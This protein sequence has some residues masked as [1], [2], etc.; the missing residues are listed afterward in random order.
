MRVTIFSFFMAIIWSSIIIIIQYIFV[1]KRSFVKT[2][3]IYSILFLYMFSALRILLPVELPFTKAFDNAF[4]WN[5]IYEFLCLEQVSI[6][7][8]TFVRVHL[9]LMLWLSG[10]IFLSIWYFIRYI[11]AVRNI[12][13]LNATHYIQAESVLLEVM[14]RVGKQM[15]VEV[16]YIP[17]VASPVGI[18][19]FNK[20]VLLPLRDCSEDELYYILMHE[21]THFLNKDISVKIL[22]QIFCCIF[23]WNPVVYLLRKDL[24]QLLEIK[25]DLT[26]IRDMDKDTKINYLSTIVRVVKERT[27]EH[28]EKQM[29]GRIEGLEMVSVIG[30]PLESNLI[31]RF[32]I[33]ADAKPGKNR[34]WINIAWYVGSFFVVLGSYMFVVQP[35]F[36]TPI[37]EI[38]TEESA[39][40]VTTDNAFVIQKEDGTYVFVCDNGVEQT[41]SKK[42]AQK[43]EADGFEII[44]EDDVMKGERK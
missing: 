43:L 24:E 32:R 17:L 30:H 26:I 35:Y 37:E 20:K 2:F 38:E 28:Q 36:D 3:G 22:I 11:R 21:V 33:V 41:I 39:Y 25:C 16:L 40:A 12:N 19:V 23:W 6:A 4:V 1:K 13:K 5:Q 31:E 29:V 34:W 8:R 9:L 14:D 10:T 42:G 7:G 44:S 18:G 15:K 27:G